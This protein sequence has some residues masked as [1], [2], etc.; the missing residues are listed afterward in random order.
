MRSTTGPDDADAGAGVGSAV[1]MQQ[2][3]SC[4]HVVQQSIRV[5]KCAGNVRV[6]GEQLTQRVPPLVAGTGRYEV[7][8]QARQRP[9]NAV[10]KGLP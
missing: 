10:R 1:L 8:R 5:F 6:S 2:L 7:S 4:Y 3:H 9:I